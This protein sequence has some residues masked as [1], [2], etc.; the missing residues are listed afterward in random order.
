[1]SFNA[2]NRRDLVPQLHIYYSEGDVLS[3]MYSLVKLGL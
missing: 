3:E 2:I 1:M